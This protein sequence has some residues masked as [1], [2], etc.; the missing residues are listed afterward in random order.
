MENTRLIILLR[1]LNRKER[2]ELRKFISTPFFNQRQDVMDLFE[3]LDEVLEKGKEAPDKVVIFRKLYGDEKYDDHKVRMAMSFL[4]KLC[5]RYLVHAQFFEDEVG[6]KTE[7][8][9]IYRQRNLPKHFERAIRETKNAQEKSEFRNSDFFFHEHR[10]RFEEFR[11]Y[12]SQR[13]TSDLNFQS[14][15]DQ[16]DIAY[17]S[18]KIRHAC[19][20]VSHQAVYSGVD[21]D[22]GLLEEILKRIKEKGLLEVP[23]ISVY[24]YCFRALTEPEETAHFHTLKEVLVSE[25]GKFPLN[26][27]A[28][29]YLIAINIC[30]KRY[31]EGQRDFLDDQFDLYKS[32]LKRGIFLNNGRLSRFTYR[33]VVALGLVLNEFEWVEQFINDF[34]IYLE[35]KHRESMYSFNLAR[36]EHHRKNYGA[37]LH[38]LQQSEYRDLLLNLAAKAL[39][40]KVYFET[41]EYD[42]L[43]SHLDAMSRFIRRKNVI[44]YHREGYLTFIQ[45]TRKLME[46]HGKSERSSLRDEIEKT[47]G[48]AEQEWLLAQFEG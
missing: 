28:D 3:T 23:A 6:A 26:E 16:L 17:F 43:D 4:M 31:N 8:A 45:F 37:A 30:I 24:Y 39:M 41:D 46:V 35:P 18:E 44:G 19:A 12:S 15:T 5:E 2:R 11:Y 14:V 36:L 1:T 20:M 48:V 22:F 10:L 29:I 40:L 33:N 21:Y 42:A 47:K 9:S 25:A 7:L 13:R 38:L 32:G 34:R 27:V